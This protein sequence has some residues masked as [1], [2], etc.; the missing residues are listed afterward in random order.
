MN[1]DDLEKETQIDLFWSTNQALLGRIVPEIRAISVDYDG[2]FLYLC[3]YSE[4]E[5]S[6]EDKEELDIAVTEIICDVMRRMGI[7]F[8][9]V[10]MPRK[11][12]IRGKLFFRRKESLVEE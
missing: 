2:D 7:Q 3:V 1:V 4:S 6:G 9:V 10:P 5:L 8:F 11:L 12:A